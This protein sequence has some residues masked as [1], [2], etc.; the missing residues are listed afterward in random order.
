MAGHTRAI[1]FA[2]P[3]SGRSKKWVFRA[4]TLCDQVGIKL[5]GTYFDLSPEGVAEAL[6]AARERDVAVVLAAGGDG[7]VGTVA[8][9]LARSDFTLG[10]L[11]AGTSNDFAR[12]LDIP[13]NVEGALRV[14]AGGRATRIDLGQAGDRRFCHAATI[15]INT[16]FAMT[17]Q[18]LRPYLRR[19]SYPVAAA[20]VYR[21][22]KRFRFRI[23]RDG[24]IEEFQP[25]EVALVN[26]PVYGGPL[27]L[28]VSQSELN[29]RKLQMVVVEDIK[30]RTLLSAIPALLQRQ[31]LRLPGV[32][33][34]PVISARIDTDPA[35]QVTLDGEPGDFTPE[36]VRIL[37]AALRV[38]VPDTFGG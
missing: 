28:H 36:H 6:E 22:R 23:E 31:P 17:A 32:E 5:Q 19:L 34:A 12:S 29:D 16:E 13:L 38:F 4:V 14:I 18:R 8:G 1:L 27:D 10:V 2:N 26:A 11:P 37:P 9:A 3:R 15:G 33:S 20:T 7:T 30:L 24:E 35:L 25:F 21:R